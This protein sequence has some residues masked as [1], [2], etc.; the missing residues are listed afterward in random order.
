M[1]KKYPIDEN[2]FSCV[3]KKT[4]AYTWK[5]ILRNRVEFKKVSA[6]NQVMVIASIF[7]WNNWYANGCLYTLIDED[8]TSL[9]DIK[10]KVSQFIIHTK[11]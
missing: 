1:Q 2:F 11:A 8:N 7:G 3:P 10:L 5:F 6:T 9:T 4:N